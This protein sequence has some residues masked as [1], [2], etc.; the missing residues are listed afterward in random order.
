MQ[1]MTDL[2]VWKMVA[3]SR[4]G[5]PLFSL[6]LHRLLLRRDFSP[7]YQKVSVCFSFDILMLLYSAFQF[8]I[9]CADG[10]GHF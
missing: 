9:T 5:N 1:H 2:L 7:S 10:S 6:S 3:A 8:Y 4:M